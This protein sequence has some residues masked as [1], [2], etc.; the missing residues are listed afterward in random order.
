MPTFLVYGAVAVAAAVS[1]ALV[2]Q[3]EAPI[4][5]NRV[6]LGKS[7]YDVL[8]LQAPAVTA[9]LLQSFS[10]LATKTR[11]GQ[12]IRRY[13]LEKNGL[14][15]LRELSAQIDLPPMHYPI[16]RLNREEWA[17]VAAPADA[18]PAEAM[19]TVLEAGF[20]YRLPAT[21]DR[22]PPLLR[23]IT[24][25]AIA[26]RRQTATPSGVM[27][28]TL[29]T[30]KE[31]ENQGFY[32]FSSVVEEDVMAQA[33]AADERQRTGRF[34][35]VFDGVPIALKDCMGVKGHIIYD[36]RSPKQEHMGS[37][38]FPQ[39]DDEIV[40]RLREAGA[41]ILGMTIMVEGGVSPLGYNSH[42]KGPVSPYSMDRYS[43]GS[44]GGSA[45]AGNRKCSFN[46]FVFL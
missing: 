18:D 22:A 43:G 32:I 30:I 8:P 13:L 39:E 5:G 27:R 12:Y 19:N 29:D 9:G 33:V 2:M 24:D 17:A 21:V 42:W 25:Y 15:I 35:S 23:S 28:K 34:L 26:Y 44:S 16:R 31:W 41:I 4:T 36:G 11:F 37:W 46:I 7:G 45:V 14:V 6:E 40:R 10:F 20:L 38:W 3:S 1:I